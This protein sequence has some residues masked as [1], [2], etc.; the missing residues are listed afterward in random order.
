MKSYWI[1]ATVVFFTAWPS[2]SKAYG[3]D[4]STADQVQQAQS[5]SNPSAAAQGSA[6]ARTE[7]I[8]VK[9]TA[10]PEAA[11]DAPAASTQS[12]GSY[13]LVELSKTLKAKKLKP[14]DKVKAEV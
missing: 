4:Q 5:S 2:G 6:Q 10:T 3:V 1:A 11:A 13:L 7:G 8:S 9:T 14:G 12:K